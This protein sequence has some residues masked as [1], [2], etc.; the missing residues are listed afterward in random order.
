MCTL[1]S[2]LA[3]RHISMVNKNKTD[4]RASLKTDGSLLTILKVKLGNPNQSHTF[5]LLT[6]LKVKLGNPNRSHTFNPSSSLIK[7]KKEHQ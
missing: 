2:V 1:L 6:I 4:F 5:N 3:I 7:T